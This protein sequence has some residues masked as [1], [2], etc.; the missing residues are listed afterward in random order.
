M[1]EKALRLRELT[2][3]ER[4]EFE[5]ELDLLKQVLKKNEE[6]LKSLQ[7]D[8]YQTGIIATVLIFICFLVYVVQVMFQNKSSH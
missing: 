1:V 8:N 4:T 2:P 3:D 6:Q 7:K 5:M